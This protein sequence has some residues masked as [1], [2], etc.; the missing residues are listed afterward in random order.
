MR[1]LMMSVC[2]SLT[3][4]LAA[5]DNHVFLLSVGVFSET[6][7]PKPWAKNVV[8]GISTILTTGCGNVSA[9]F[10]GHGRY[11]PELPGVFFDNVP[12]EVKGFRLSEFSIHVVESIGRCKII[13]TSGIIAG[14]AFL[15]GPVIVRR[16][17]SVARDAQVWAHEMGHAQGLIGAFSG[18]V[19]GHNPNAGA[20]MF[21]SAGTT[22]VGLSSQ[23]CDA[24]REPQAFAITETQGEGTPTD[25]TEAPAEAVTL[26]GADAISAAD[27]LEMEWVHGIDVDVI[28]G[29]RI[30]MADAASVA[31]RTDDFSK[32]PNAVLAVGYLNAADAMA[33][34]RKVTD[35][36]GSLLA[37]E[38]RFFVD[39]AK[40]NAIIGIGY[41]A[42]AGVAEAQ[43]FL[44]S[45]TPSD[46]AL[47]QNF[48][49]AVPEVRET[50]QVEAA[51]HTLIALGFAAA[52]SP[53]AAAMLARQREDEAGRR[54]ANGNGETVALF[55]PT[56]DARFFD[57]LDALA[58]AGRSGGVRGMLEER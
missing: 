38:D 20:L 31:I 3:A 12:A 2:I 24:F 22:N 34:L 51:R 9:Q 37:E 36:D 8:G 39:E 16:R 54:I 14:C 49:N 45:V 33:L 11:A 10:A 50:L 13:P 55:D 57:E 6:A 1:A 7:S 27:L 21:A 30:D 44:T 28:D 53:E 26:A 58:A 42:A 23:E 32:W 29:M 46:R 56:L 43:A 41:L 19:N 35:F 5:A 52:E 15:G 48:S 18:Y 47:S 4:G 25:E 40:L 17:A